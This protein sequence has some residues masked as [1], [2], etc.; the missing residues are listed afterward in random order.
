[1]INDSV[2]KCIHLLLLLIGPAFVLAQQKILDSLHT[3]LSQAPNDTVR[4]QLYKK[5]GVYYDEVNLDS[6]QY[7]SEKGIA[8][9]ER[10]R[11]K[12]DQAEMLMNLS[13]PLTK[14]GNYPRSLKVLM[15]ASA[16]AGDS[17]SEQ[18]TWHLSPKQTTQ[19]YRV[20]IL[21]Y[22]QLAQGFLY[23]FTGYPDKQIA[24]YQEGIR[25]AASVK[26]TL[27]LCLIYGDLSGAYLDKGQ[28]DSTLATGDIAMRY[29]YRL[30]VTDW[31]FA[32]SVFSLM[33]RAYLEKGDIGR[34][35]EYFEQ[36][37]REGEA[38]NNLALVGD[39]NM[40]LAGILKDR[41]RTDSGLYHVKKA[42]A[43][44]KSLGNDRA[45]AG[46]YKTI[47]ALY[48]QQKNKD[49]L[50]AYITL[51]TN[52]QDSLDE[53][54]KAKLHEYQIVG[55]N[56]QL[57]QQELEKERTATQNR[58]RTYVMLGGIVILLLI[59]FLLYWNNQTKKKAN[60]LLQKQNEEIAQQRNQLERALSELKATQAQL[61]QAEKMASLGELTAGIAHEIQNPLNF[62]NNFSDLNRELIEDMV[63]AA[64]ENDA[65]EVL[66]LA[67]QLKENEEKNS[68]H[69]KR[70]D[71]IVKAMLQHSR[72][73]CGQK[74][75]TDINDLV[76]ECL[77]LAF[78][79]MQAKEKDFK[80][81]LEANYDSRA[82]LIPVIPQDIGRILLN[83]F[84]NAFYTVDEKK[85]LHP[86]G[87]EPAVSVST[88]RLDDKMEIRI[89]DNGMGMP[90]EVKEKI[91]QP[92]FTTKRTGQGT[93]LGLSLSYD[94]VK[95][96]G[97]N[98]R[99]E[100]I[101]GK[102]TTITIAI[103]TSSEIR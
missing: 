102:G 83:V 39:G 8:I 72:G 28:I 103:P 27:L 15:Q 86:E 79:G 92:L 13:F 36:T 80:V 38:Y 10:F 95:A 88:M 1:M 21:G 71:A 22:V 29:Y 43:A 63:R 2:K 42:L 89:T 81:S 100:S 94:I 98:I 17:S 59:A 65:P 48:R 46:A 18:H 44:Y 99:V 45:M 67:N 55:F 24:A 77:R 3:V 25:L 31:K 34:A 73:G 7:Y 66:K 69:G 87:Y 53:A 70:A 23:D 19:N 60:G 96:H 51:A 5:L 61:I 58:I 11:L 20:S 82:G 101:P 54:E 68:L 97:G 32:G 14:L 35:R 30:P 76:D 52:L 85:K 93:G 75:K 26:D 57:R 49:S 47:A 33:G 64:R 16:I 4:M 6:S 40:L 62:V 56:D 90:E 91:F 78:H 84:S 41:D 74:E 9:A 37:I 50:L 12:G